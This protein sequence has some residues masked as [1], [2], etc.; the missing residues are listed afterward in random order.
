MKERPIL[1][2]TQRVAALL[3]GQQ[4]Q[5]RRIMKSFAFSR[6]QDNHEGCYGFDVTS[7][8]QQGFYAL[9][10]EDVNRHCPFGQPGDRLWVRE[11]WRGP[12]VPPERLEEYARAPDTFRQARWCQYLADRGSAIAA[13]TDRDAAGW[14]T[15]VHMPRWASRLHLQIDAVR[16]ERLHDIS[17]ADVVAEGIGPGH[18]FLNQ[19]FAEPGSAPSARTRYKQYWEKHYGPNSWNVNPWVWVIDFHILPAAA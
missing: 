1:F 6:G 13:E 12:V 19:F 11:T 9:G 8:H 5:T 4:T 16:V 14:Q 7:H 15:A 2:S 18:H 10:M 17:E 3:S